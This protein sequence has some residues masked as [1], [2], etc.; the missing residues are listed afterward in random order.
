MTILL[1][2]PMQFSFDTIVQGKISFQELI[3]MKK[4]SRDKR[5]DRINRR[6]FRRVRIC[7]NKRDRNAGRVIQHASQR[8]VRES[9][10]ARTHART[11]ACTLVRAPV[12]FWRLPSR[13][14]VYMR[15]R[16]RARRN[17]AR[18]LVLSP[19][20]RR[21]RQ[22]AVHVHEEHLGYLKRK[23]EVCTWLRVYLPRR[24]G[25]GGN[26]GR[27][28]ENGRR[29]DSGVKGPGCQGRLLGELGGGREGWRAG[30]YDDKTFALS[31]R[32]GCAGGREGGSMYSRRG[33]V[34]VPEGRRG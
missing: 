33:S 22:N 18:S 30:W 13:A 2:P 34:T 17:G 3:F 32:A 8:S 16:A 28:E 11:L 23:F 15:A 7:P 1:F 26:D 25:A 31:F 12:R 21:R 29:G 4:R 10:H 6:D 14:Q 9:T 27:P 5:D 24:L 20:R 19:F